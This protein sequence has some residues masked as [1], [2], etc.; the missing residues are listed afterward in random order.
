MDDAL[1][2]ITIGRFIKA[3]AVRGW[4]MTRP[5]TDQATYERICVTGM[6]SIPFRRTTDGAIAHVL[7]IAGN[8]HDIVSDASA[9]ASVFDSFDRDFT[10]A[11]KDVEEAPAAH[12]AA[13]G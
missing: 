5:R 2:L 9:N 3:M 11:C 12:P 4:L 13:E 7:F 10:A 1:E 8:G 6:A